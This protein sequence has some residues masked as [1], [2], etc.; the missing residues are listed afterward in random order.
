MLIS[1]I[2]NY[3]SSMWGGG[4]RGAFEI[5]L[6]NGRGGSST[7]VLLINARS[8]TKLLKQDPLDD[9]A[10][11]MGKPQYLSS[12]DDK[13]KQGLRSVSIVFAPIREGRMVCAFS[14]GTSRGVGSFQP[15]SPP[16]RLEP[17]IARK[18]K[19]TQPPI[20]DAEPP[21]KRGRAEM[22]RGKVGK[23]DQVIDMEIGL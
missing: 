7:F 11:S 20:R 8:A 16:T 5:H 12:P 2:P 14:P 4:E 10:S 17:T 13:P 22:P 21:G 6:S 19:C 9:P 15:A 18:G 3:L 1:R 23:G